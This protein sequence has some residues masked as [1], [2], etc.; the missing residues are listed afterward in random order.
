M[1]PELRYYFQHWGLTLSDEQFQAI[2][3]KFD[4]D[5]DGKISYKDFHMT[6]GGEIHPGESLYFR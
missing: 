4:F 3:K 2:F 5:G 6:I 1:A